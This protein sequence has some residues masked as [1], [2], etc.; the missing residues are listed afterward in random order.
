MAICSFLG[1]EIFDTGL[2]AKI[3]MAVNQIVEDNETIVFLLDCHG[4]F[5]SKCILAALRAKARQPQKVTITLVL[6]KPYTSYMQH[7]DDGI[8]SS[9]ALAIRHM[10]T[11]QRVCAGWQQPGKVNRSTEYV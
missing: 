2:D 5:Y 8:P 10:P 4:G 7:Q 1:G 6:N 11:F 3:E 9:T